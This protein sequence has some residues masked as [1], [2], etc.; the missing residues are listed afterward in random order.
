MQQLALAGKSQSGVR[1]VFR[2]WPTSRPVS[3]RAVLVFLAVSFLPWIMLHLLLVVS[4]HY[5]MTETSYWRMFVNTV[6]NAIAY[7]L[8]TPGM[9]LLGFRASQMERGKAALV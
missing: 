2:V 5:G 1:G 9:I 3:A 7:W 8:L 6:G 4:F